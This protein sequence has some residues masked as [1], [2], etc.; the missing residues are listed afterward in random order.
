MHLLKFFSKLRGESYPVNYK[1]QHA[2]DI[3]TIPTALHFRN[4]KKHDYVKY[5]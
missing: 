4:A 3:C 5:C 1:S 2:S